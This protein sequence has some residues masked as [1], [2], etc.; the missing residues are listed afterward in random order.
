MNPDEFN[1]QSD[2]DESLFDW[3]EYH[4]YVNLICWGMLTDVGILILK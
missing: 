4:F 3:W 1:L 2:E